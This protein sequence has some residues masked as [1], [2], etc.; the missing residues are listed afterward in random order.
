MKIWKQ[1]SVQAFKPD[2]YVATL[3]NC[4]LWVLYGMPFVKPDSILVVSINGT[5][6]VIESFYITIFI[7]FSDWP[8]R[9]RT[10][11]FIKFYIYQFFIFA[12]SSV[13]K[14]ISEALANWLL[15]LFYLNQF[16]WFCLSLA[17]SPRTKLNRSGNT[18]CQK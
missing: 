2:P 1:K 11:A 15:I 14:T 18:V 7:I 3:L 13:I 8:K 16:N 5:G 4:L 6:L 12:F 17:L 9:V 10:T